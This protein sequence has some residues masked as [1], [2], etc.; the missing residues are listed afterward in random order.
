MASRDVHLASRYSMSEIKMPDHK[1]IFDTRPV[2]KP[3]DL[4]P[5][6]QSSVYGSLQSMS[7]VTPHI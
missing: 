2:Q 4:W 5:G 1:E 6:K 3:S 7:L